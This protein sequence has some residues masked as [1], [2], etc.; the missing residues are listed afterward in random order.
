M[1]ILGIETSCDETAAAVIRGERDKIKVLSN[2]VSSQINI[3]KQ[4]GGVVPEVAAREHV[5]KILPVINQALRQAKI[6]KEDAPKKIDAIA[7]AV[8]PGL[9]TSLL[10]GVETAKTLAAGWSLPLTAVNHINAHI[11]ANFIKPVIKINFPVLVLT[12]SGGHTVLVLM[13]GHGDYKIIGETRDDAVGE[14]FDKAAQLLGLG[15]P[16]GP[17]I[18]RL[19]ALNKKA[20]DKTDISL[21]RPMLKDKSYDFSF[22]GLKTALLYAL[23]QDKN[24]RKKISAYSYEFQQAATDVLINKTLRAAKEFKVNTVALTG[25]VSANSFLRE[26]MAKVIKKEIP[27]GKFLVPP[28]EYTTDNAAMVAAA[29]YFEARAGKFIKPEKLKADPNIRI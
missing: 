19:A 27:G 9:I 2:I 14:A 10:V 4:Y 6:K 13:R 22:S 12:A 29:G 26:R 7:V 11:Y 20:N 18:S 5:I 28:L 23:K 24:W 16:G 8:G 3:H 15:Y 1:L 17:A 25:G 21:P